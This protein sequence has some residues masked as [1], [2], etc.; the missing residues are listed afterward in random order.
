MTLTSDSTAANANAMQEIN[1]SPDPRR[2]VNGLRDAGYNLNTAIADIVDNS[3]NARAD[4]VHV[5][6]TLDPAEKLTSAFTTT[7]TA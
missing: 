7:A 2:I 1:N 5:R 4:N 6:L 3:I